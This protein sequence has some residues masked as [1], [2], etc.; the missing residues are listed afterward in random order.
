MPTEEELKE[1][2]IK[3]QS[4]DPSSAPPTDQGSQV[5]DPSADKGETPQDLPDITLDGETP[6]LG[7]SSP[8]QM[9]KEVDKTLKEAGFNLEDIQKE[10]TE[11][12]EIS[13]DLVARIKESVDPKYV[14][15]HLGRLRAELELQKLRA[16]PDTT[17]DAE[18]TKLVQDMNTYIFDKVKGEK[19]FNSMSGYLRDNLPEAELVAINEL[20]QSGDKTKVD[21]AL[22]TAVQKYNTLK[23]RGKLMSGDQETPAEFTP[24]SKNK[25]WE[26]IKTEKYRT[27]RVYQKSVDAQRI[28]T[29]ALDK[30]KYPPGMY[31]KH[32]PDGLERL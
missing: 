23:G 28:K 11:K 3:I 18:A 31:F 17:A 14:D 16:E 22:T 15:A 26:I 7:E 27:D 8:E 10:I 5:A 9:N 12:G 24:M 13:D 20:L 29:K 25:Y 1:T 19:N 4:G 21:M 32:G 6:V 2:P 30:Q